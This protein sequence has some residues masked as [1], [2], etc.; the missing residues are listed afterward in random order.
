MS[1]GAA[2]RPS[3]RPVVKVLSSTKEVRDCARQVL[4]FNF[5]PS[6]RGGAFTYNMNVGGGGTFEKQAVDPAVIK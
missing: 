2:M 3:G 1:S 4:S 6:P 5:D